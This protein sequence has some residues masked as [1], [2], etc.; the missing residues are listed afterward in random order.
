MRRVS[1]GVLERE[2]SIALLRKHR[3][4]SEQRDGGGGAAA[5]NG[6]DVAAT[7]APLVPD[8]KEAEG[9]AVSV[10]QAESSEEQTKRAAISSGRPR[11][12][13]TPCLSMKACLI[14]TIRRWLAVTR[15][16]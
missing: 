9:V 12:L 16:S 14:S 3:E 8:Q 6:E 13:A 1:I 2:K 15:S 10:T 5:G 4:E 11:N 7:L